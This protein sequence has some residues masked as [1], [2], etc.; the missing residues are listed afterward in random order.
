MMDEARRSRGVVVSSPATV[1]TVILKF[2]ESLLTLVNEVTHRNVVPMGSAVRADGVTMGSPI[3]SFLNRP[4]VLS[5][6]ATF[7]LRV[8]QLEEST[9]QWAR[10][11]DRFKKCVLIMDELDFVC[12]PVSW[13]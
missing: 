7:Q 13:P 8:G 9:R 11:L 3:Q 6:T 1:K 4:P 2:V 12:H 5:R 10:L